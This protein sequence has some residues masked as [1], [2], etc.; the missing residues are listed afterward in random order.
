MQV[1]LLGGPKDGG[2]VDI[3][4]G[5]IGNSP[6][7]DDDFELYFPHDEQ[8]L[9]PIATY[10]WLFGKADHLDFAGWQRDDPPAQ[11]LYFDFM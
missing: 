9:H 1:E 6:F 2:F 4:V 7:I 11:Q 3:V 5:S 10:R 8:T